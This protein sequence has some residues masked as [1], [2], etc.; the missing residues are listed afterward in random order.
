MRPKLTYG[1][2]VA[3]LACLTATLRLA[4]LGHR[5]ERAGAEPD[6]APETSVISG[7]RREL[8]L[9]SLVLR[10]LE[11]RISKPKTRP[12]ASFAT[13]PY[14]QEVAGSSPAPP[15]TPNSTPRARDVGSLPRSGPNP[16][17]PNGNPRAG[18]PYVDPRAH[19][20]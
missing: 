19:E 15:I 18:S 4:G 7:N 2:V 12:T 10:T 5:P 16:S 3:T 1:N 20:D 8:V 17:V 14:K 13:P 9:G 6:S 11:S